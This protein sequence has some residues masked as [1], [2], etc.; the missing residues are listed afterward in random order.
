MLGEHEAVVVKQLGNH[1][2]MAVVEEQMR[3]LRRKH[4]V[5]VMRLWRNQRAM[6]GEWK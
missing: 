1:R 4:R 6:L 3:K 5:M 2:A